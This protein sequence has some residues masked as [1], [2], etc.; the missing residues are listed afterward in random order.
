M[1]KKIKRQK[2]A[3]K[4]KYKLDVHPET[5]RWIW[6][7]LFMVIAGISVLA[8]FD[9]AGLFGRFIITYLTLFLGQAKF[10]F[11]VIMAALGYFILVSEK[12]KVKSASYI[13]LFFL[14]L[15]L[16]AI[17]H[18][19]VPYEKQVLAVEQGVGGGYLGLILGHNLQNVMGFW[20]SLIVLVALLLVSFLLILN[21]SISEAITHLKQSGSLLGIIF[22]KISIWWYDLKLKLAGGNPSTE[23]G[24]REK[25]ADESEVKGA[26][27]ELNFSTKKVEGEISKTNKEELVENLKDEMVLEKPKKITYKKIDLPI[28]LLDARIGKPTSGNIAV[29]KLKIQKTLESFNIPVEMGD[30]A[31]GPTVTQYT[32]K[33]SEGIKL[34]RI[35]ALSDDM[36]LSLAAH[37]LRIEAPIPGKSLVGIEVPNQSVAIVRL[38]ELLESSTFKARKSNLFLPLGKDVSGNTW[39][40]DIAK[41]PHLLV[42]GA[43][44]SGKSVCLNTIIISLLYQNGPD[45]LKFIMV[46]PKRVELPVY[47]D[48][49]HLLTPV[50]TD[51]KKTVNALKWAIAE[52]DRRYIFLEKMKK[53]NIESYNQ[54]ASEKMP[55]IM[56]IVDEMADLMMNTGH[57]VE[58]LI[59]RLAQM[60]RAVGIHL[61]LATQRPSV[62]VITGL[63]KAN[64]PC[65]IAFAVASLMDSRTILDHSGAEKLVGK[66]DMLYTAP[67]ISKPKRLQGAYLADDEI[68]RVVDFIKDSGQKPDYNTDIVEKQKNGENGQIDFSDSDDGDELFDEAKQIVLQAGK[69]STSFL[70]RRLKIG[71]SRAARLI[72]LMEQAGIVGPADGAKP[73]EILITTKEVEPQ[74]DYEGPDMTET[75]EDDSDLPVENE[76]EEVVEEAAETV[77]EPE[78]EVAH[79]IE[80][81][82]EEVEEETVEEES[83]EVEEKEEKVNKKMTEE[84]YSKPEDDWIV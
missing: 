21:R 24:A 22:S 69:A 42:A 36:A 46:D 23:L 73:R 35:T 75:K 39:V 41:M 30:V 59:V 72:D 52:M 56:I 14:V 29:N 16:T 55:Y 83:E 18:L 65:R 8:M 49:P 15:S 32:L 54:V 4:A 62:N 60:A 80:K 48:I 66:G 47:N 57:E 40:A 51:L 31:V 67:E 19:S 61:I 34:S 68:K 58:A 81:P 7:I 78:K 17:L 71:Y 26:T 28:D 77:Q 9:L 2:E 12:K 70:Q 45:M 84:E 43:T 53:R 10:I 64:I 5:Q 20:A 3:V 33:P 37:P 27:E 63:I 25:D 76:D 11:P 6:S 50:I 1:G 82:T 38:R 79:A 13:G 44:G 74:S